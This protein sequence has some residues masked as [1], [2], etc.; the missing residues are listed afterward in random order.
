[1]PKSSNVDTPSNEPFDTLHIEVTEHPF[2]F[3]GDERLAALV[4]E[5]VN[6]MGGFGEDAE[7]Q[8]QRH[9]GVLREQGAEV[10]PLITD[11]YPR[12]PDSAYVDRWSLIQLL[13]DL[14]SPVATG[15]L[16]EFLAEEI[17]EESSHDPHSFS[18]VAEEVMIRTTAVEALA[19]VAARGDPDAI[20]VLHEQVRHPQFSIRRAA[21]QALVD[22][23][24]LRVLDRLREELSETGELRLLD[25]KRIDVTEAPQATG[26]LFLARPGTDERD[27]PPPHNFTGR[28]PI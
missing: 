20:G 27:E 12:L 24:D 2:T 10:V 4:V 13:A 5:A 6:L 3:R 8:Y 15:P 7:D 23:G 26:G 17:P 16:K 9:L 1:M 18:T 11:A 22:T 28:Q 21:V 14:E 25:I 19:R